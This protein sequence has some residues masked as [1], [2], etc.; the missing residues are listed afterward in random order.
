MPAQHHDTVE[1]A[2]ATP[3]QAMANVPYVGV[4]TTALDPYLPR[5]FFDV[6]R[7][8]VADPEEEQHARGGLQPMPWPTFT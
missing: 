4:A 6:G 5:R 3:D 1:H 8:A 7:L 2:A